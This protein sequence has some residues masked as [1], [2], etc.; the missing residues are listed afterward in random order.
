MT[1]EDV[2]FR[3]GT[4]PELVDALE[5]DVHDPEHELSEGLLV[6]HPAEVVVDETFE[7]QPQEVVDDVN[8]IVQHQEVVHHQEVADDANFI[9]HPEDLVVDEDLAVHHEKVVVAENLFAHSEE[10]VVN[11]ELVVENH[12]SLHCAHFVEVV[13]A[14]SSVGNYDNQQTSDERLDPPQEEALDQVPALDPVP[15]A[16]H[17]VQGAYQNWLSNMSHTVSLFQGK[18]RC[19][20]QYI[21]F[22]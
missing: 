4:L 21:S 7:V 19:F 11:A 1:S 10:E 5:L 17:R 3:V 6:V 22:R 14:E 20:Y 8:L 9:V 13:D 15:L 2:N 12:Y 16:F 18:K